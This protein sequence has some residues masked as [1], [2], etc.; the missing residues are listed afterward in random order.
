MLNKLNSLRIKVVK[1][2]YLDY[3]NRINKFH[4]KLR[5]YIKL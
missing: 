5:V 1:V 2:L 4:M 3:N